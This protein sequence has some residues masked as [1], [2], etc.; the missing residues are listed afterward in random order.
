MLSFPIGQSKSMA[1][2]EWYADR[3]LLLTGVTSDLGR[4]LLEKILRSFSN[5]KVYTVLRSR[6]GS[7]KEDRIRN[8]F[9]SPRYENLKIIQNYFTIQFPLLS[10]R[11]WE[12]EAYTNR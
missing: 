12:Q 7:D 2:R 8:I 9:L 4:A 6:N 10:T 11:S 1:L 3:E 5:V